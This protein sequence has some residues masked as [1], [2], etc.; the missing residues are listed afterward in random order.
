MNPA[1]EELLAALGPDR[2]KTGAD[3]PARNA[4]DAAKLPAVSSTAR[5][6]DQ[7]VASRMTSLAATASAGEVARVVGPAC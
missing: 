7:G 1:I 2:V 5:V 4:M 6:A 3:I